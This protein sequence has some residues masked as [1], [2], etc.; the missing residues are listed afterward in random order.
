[1][2]VAE[3]GREEFEEAHASVIAGRGDELGHA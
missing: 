1:V 3:V 2:R